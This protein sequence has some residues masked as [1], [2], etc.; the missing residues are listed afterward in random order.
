MPPNPGLGLLQGKTAAQKKLNGFCF[1]H[2][3]CFRVFDVFVV[4]VIVLVVFVVVV[5]VVLVVVVVV[6]AVVA[7]LVVVVVV[8]VVIVVVL[9]V[10]V[11][12]VVFFTVAV[13][14]VFVV[15]VN[16]EIRC[17]CWLRL[18]TREECGR[19][20]RFGVAKGA[21]RSRRAKNAQV[22]RKEKKTNP[23]EPS[24]SGPSRVCLLQLD[25]SSS[26]THLSP[27]RLG[28]SSETSAKDSAYPLA[29]PP[30]HFHSVQKGFHMIFKPLQACCPNHCLLFVLLQQ[31]P[32]LRTS[33]RRS[34]PTTHLQTSGSGFFDA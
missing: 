21:S 10:F 2:F 18:S 9:V 25:K 16:V 8:V 20:A 3:E 14:V 28:P 32:N 31:H 22:E 7:G 13:D 5:V 27:P 34:A 24:A 26:S 11:V 19:G 29:H 12:V 17:L 23:R 15:V 33:C 4:M 30:C 6:V 1:P